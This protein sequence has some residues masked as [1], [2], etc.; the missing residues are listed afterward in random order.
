MKILTNGCSYTSGF[1]KETDMDDYEN[2]WPYYLGQSMKAD[3]TNLAIHGSGNNR[4]LLDTVMEC[5]TNDYD[6][7]CIGWTEAARIDLPAR[8]SDS[9]VDRIFIE[10][11]RKVWERQKPLNWPT[12]SIYEDVDIISDIIYRWNKADAKTMMFDVLDRWYSTVV[13]LAR[14]LTAKKIP[15]YFAQSIPLVGYNL[16][17]GLEYEQTTSIE[18]DYMIEKNG[19]IERWM[20][21]QFYGWPITRAL[22][23][24]TLYDRCFKYMKFADIVEDEVKRNNMMQRRE[25]VVFD[26]H[27]SP[28]G[29]RMIASIFEEKIN[30]LINR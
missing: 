5:E 26:P 2:C 23:G 13:C 11:Y 24:W 20:D 9:A 30:P 8:N 15:Y 18:A 3:V 7:V 16:M 4:I 22:N 25:Q 17:L 6:A 21:K 14:Y 27:P 19:R 28:D 1:T 29:H 10:P 12:E